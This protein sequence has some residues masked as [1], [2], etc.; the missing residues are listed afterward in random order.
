MTKL[1]SWLRRTRSVE[2]GAVRREARCHMGEMNGPPTLTN[3]AAKSLAAGA[4]ERGGLLRAAKRNRRSASRSLWTAKRKR[5]LN[6]IHYYFEFTLKRYI[7]H[8]IKQY[9][10]IIKQPIV[11][12]RLSRWKHEEEFTS[13]QEAERLRLPNN[14]VSRI[15]DLV[16]GD[17][18]YNCKIRGQGQVGHNAIWYHYQRPFFVVAS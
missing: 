3:G 2:F 17:S 4:N 1:G 8:I 18:N 5:R 9:H 12:A 6:R 11:F 13:Q 16:R 7:Y 15:T 10:H 14:W